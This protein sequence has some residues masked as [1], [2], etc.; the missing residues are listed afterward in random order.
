MHNGL[1]LQAL[2]SDPSQAALQSKMADLDRR[3]QIVDRLVQVHEVLQTIAE[4]V[5]ERYFLRAIEHLEA[6][7]NLIARVRCQEELEHSV[8][9][10]LQ[11]EICILRE[12]LLYELGETWSKLLKW[13]PSEA[14]APSGKVSLEVS[15]AEGHRDLLTT[16]AQA[17]SSV[18][19]L[20]SRIK[21]LCDRLMVCVVKGVVSDRSTLL[22]VVDEADTYQLIL[23]S[24]TASPLSPVPPS[25]AF[26]KLEQV[27]LFLHRPLHDI[28]VKGESGKQ[29]G[30]L[31]EKIGENICKKLFECIYNECLS[32]AIPKTG[33][34]YW[35][36]YNEIVL[37]AEKFEDF[38]QDLD[39]FTPGGHDSLMDHLNNVNNLFAN[40][41][42]QDLIRRAHEFMTQELM[43]SVQISMEHPLG[44]IKGTESEARESYVRDCKEKSCTQKYKLPTCQVR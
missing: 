11:T 44:N 31:V 10:V 38:L 5:R 15:Q 1:F 26:Q 9:K 32:A 17:M 34:Q 8:R 35:G 37:L 41:K 2:R 6:V 43:N 7:N 40:I 33:I 14:H 28:I 16:T 36:Q 25:E 30:T 13:T 23:Q 27:F 4:G 24:V 29:A 42:S 12:K 3:L 18:G 20:D 21:G 22:Q 39:Y 19:M